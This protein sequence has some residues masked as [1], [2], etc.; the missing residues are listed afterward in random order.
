MKKTFINVNEQI[1]IGQKAK[2]SNEDITLSNEASERNTKNHKRLEVEKFILNYISRLVTGNENVELYKH[3]F[4]SMNDQQFNKFMEDL[5]DGNKFLSVIIPNGSNKIKV[6]INNNI[7][8]AKEL[9]FD[10]FQR[11]YIKN[12][13]DLPD[14][15]TPNKYMLLKLPVRRASQLVSKKISIPVDN[16]SVDMLTGQVTGK[17]KGAMLTNPELQILLGLG[18]KDSIKELMKMRGGDTGEAMAMNNML[19]SQGHISQRAAESYSTEVKSKKTLK[20]YFN[21]MGIKSTL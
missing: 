15:L 9:G 6:D 20:S 12:N 7:K 1:R 10:F 4:N 18:L 8:L 13:P 2:K 14:H 17:S 5:R 11:L 19:F 3:L 21:G 16:K